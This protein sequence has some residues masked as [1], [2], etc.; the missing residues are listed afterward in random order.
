MHAQSNS[1]PDSPQTE[2]TMVIHEVSY[3]HQNNIQDNAQ[4]I[5][6]DNLNPAEINIYPDSVLKN[7]D[8]FDPLVVLLFLVSLFLRI[9]QLFSFARK[10]NQQT[11]RSPLACLNHP[12]LRAPPAYV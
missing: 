10:P 12:P 1:V 6:L 2:A 11:K 8:L 4:N 5:N 9:P 7:I 3:L